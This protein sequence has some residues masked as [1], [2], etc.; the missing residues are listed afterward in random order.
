MTVKICGHI[1]YIKD[2]KNKL[3]IAGRNNNHIILHPQTPLY[4]KFYI[5]TQGIYP[6]IFIHK[7]IQNEY[8]V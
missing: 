5:T 2:I 3:N 4:E 6:N 7:I 8:F 1:F